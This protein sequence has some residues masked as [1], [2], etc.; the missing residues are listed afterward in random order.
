MLYMFFVNLI[1]IILHN[2]S[3][4]LSYHLSLAQLS[5]IKIVIMSHGV[6]LQIKCENESESSI[7][8]VIYNL[9]WLRKKLNCS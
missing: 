2:C 8:N 6:I 4:I 9:T 3:T 1:S 7:L 5:E